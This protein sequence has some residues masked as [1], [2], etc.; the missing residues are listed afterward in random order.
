MKRS[1]SEIYIHY[2]WGIEERSPRINQEIEHTVYQY[3]AKKS[4]EH[5]C[6]VIAIGGTSDHIHLLTRMRPSVSISDY[7]KSIKGGSSH[8]V[9]QIRHPGSGFKWQ[10]GYAAYTLSPWYLSKLIDY[11]MNQKQHHNEGTTDPAASLSSVVPLTICL[12]DN[13]TQIVSSA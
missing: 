4:K 1:K 12:C 6:S 2:I 3:I 7:V 13:F 10:G 5:G 9:N 11:I 8:Y